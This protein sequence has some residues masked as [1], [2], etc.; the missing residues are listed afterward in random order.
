MSVTTP[1]PITLSDIQ[2]KNQQLLQK[3]KIQKEQL[4]EI[5]EKEKLLLTRSRMLQIVQ[6]KNSFKKKIIYTLLSII[7]LIFIISLALYVYFVRTI[8]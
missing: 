4:L 2:L 7:F 5:Q 1:A 6:D 3:Q 8:K